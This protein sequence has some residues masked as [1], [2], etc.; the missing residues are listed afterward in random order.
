VTV[1]SAL[2]VLNA[3]AI[4]VIAAVV[5]FRV[6]S[7][8]RNPEVKEPDN[9]SPGMEDPELEGRKLERVLG[10]SLLCAS[11]IAVGLPL[12]WFREPTRQVE[13]QRGFDKRSIERGATLYAD[14]Q[15]KAYDNAKSLRC[16]TCHGGDAK[17]GTATQVIK[18]DQTGTGR[19]AQVKW[20][21]P[22]LNTV[23]WRFSPEQVTQII[24]YGRPGTP[25]P[26]WGIAG[27][28][29][30]GEQAISDLVSYLKSIQLTMKGA[31]AQT[32]EVLAGTKTQAQA[33]LDQSKNDLAAAQQALASAP[34]DKR[35]SAAKAVTAEEQAVR[36]SQARLDEVDAALANGEIGQGQL[37]FENNCAR[38][39]TRGWSYF[40]PVDPSAPLP[41]PQGSGA[42]GPKINDGDTLNQFPG[43]AGFQQQIAWV[44][45]GVEAN[46]A[47]GVRGISSGRMEHFVNVLTKE[48]IQAI[49][50]YERGL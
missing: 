19:P 27:G 30:K 48:Q 33:D 32:A 11:V 18:A 44:T 6:I 16:A 7:V 8:R 2:I 14:D 37:L 17:G 43:D 39:H 5:A 36:N 10:W 34:P 38:C 45:D 31:K 9:L 3:A 40:D 13:E 50:K 12:Y 47:Y 4:V 26:A 21:A 42:F 15:M 1:R 35:E 41:A 25:M 49:V 24:T 29:P 28:G 22:A 20:R 23:L 46:K